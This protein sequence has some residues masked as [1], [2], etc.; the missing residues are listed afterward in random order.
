MW[1]E[2]D[3]HNLMK[4]RVNGLP[5]PIKSPS[6]TCDSRSTFIN[7]Q[8]HYRI[9]IKSPRNNSNIS[10]PERMCQIDSNLCNEK[11]KGRLKGF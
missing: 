3:K 8:A 4:E 2:F 9:M 10:E 11:T 5:I 1:Q 6:T 7:R